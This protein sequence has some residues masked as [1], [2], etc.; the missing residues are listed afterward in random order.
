M[1]NEY[2]EKFSLFEEFN[3]LVDFDLSSVIGVVYTTDGYNPS[4][5]N[6]H[7]LAM[8]YN[9]DCSDE[10]YFGNASDEM[11]EYEHLFRHMVDPNAS[12]SDALKRLAEFIRKLR[13]ER[14]IPQ[15][16]VYLASSFASGWGNLLMKAAK[17]KYA[18]L[19]NSV[20]PDYMFLDPRK[21]AVAFM[22]H[23]SSRGFKTL[24][25]YMHSITVPRKG[26]SLKSLYSGFCQKEQQ[27]FG[28]NPITRAAMN[29][30]LTQ[31]LFRMRA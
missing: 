12:V 29:S 4:I 3:R 8:Y 10:F 31:C 23:K 13:E 22:E 30:I 14:L 16:K 20:V 19:F 25:D 15:G 6:W 21:L 17:D 1:N 18:S 27:V 5:D 9:N 11:L 24:D 28:T 26:Y 2:T 7:G